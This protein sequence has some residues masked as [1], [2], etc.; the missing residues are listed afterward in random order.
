MN[1]PTGAIVVVDDNEELAQTLARTFERKGWNAFTAD[2]GKSALKIIR[3]EPI[4]VLLADLRMP[5]MDG[6]ELIRAARTIVPAIE[7]L[8]LSGCGTI[9]KAVEA[10]KEGVCDFLV[11]PVKTKT[12][13]R[14]AQKALS[15]RASVIS[16]LTAINEDGN[17]LSRPLLGRSPA[18]RR[19]LELGKRAAS[20][21][22]TVLIEGESGTGKELLAE[23]IH[24]WSPRRNKPL[25]KVNCATLPENLVEAELFGYERGAFTGAYHRRHG[26]FELAH[27]G[28]I[29]LD[30]IGQFSPSLQTKLLR[31]LQSG[32]FER[33]GGNRSLVTDA[34]VIAATNSD[35]DRAV[36]DGLFRKDLFYRLNVIRLRK[37]S[38]RERP[39]D[40]PILINH[41]IEIYK[42]KNARNI[43]GITGNTLALM[44]AYQWPG[45][46]RELEHAVERAVVMCRSHVISIE[47][48][49]ES[50]HESEAGEPSVCIPVGMPLEEIELR[51]IEETLRHTHGDKKTAA[52]I[53]GIAQRTIYRK[54]TRNSKK[55]VT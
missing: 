21:S 41:F 31:V 36:K 15:H 46:V 22:A 20:S 12:L 4:D 39:S 28:T 13:I 14:A 47:D 55:S 8:V 33:L 38:L 51:M 42:R 50:L 7:A 6:L 3:S 45:N 54:L 10:M 49:P 2:S 16:K 25:V 48:L 35:L 32:E 23:A 52:D 53:L 27:G 11:K 26:R 18:I 5:G 37:P 34:R 9:P 44:C 40:I 24:R 1:E 30:E 17:R 19:I 29:F 43:K